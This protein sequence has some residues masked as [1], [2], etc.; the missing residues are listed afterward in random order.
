MH[1]GPLLIK[2]TGV[3]FTSSDLH[4]LKPGMFHHVRVEL[5]GTTEFQ[6]AHTGTFLF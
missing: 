6:L 2:T 3:M 1:G 5:H 4:A